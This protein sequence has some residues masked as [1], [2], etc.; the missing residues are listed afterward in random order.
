MQNHLE[1][2]KVERLRDIS[3]SYVKNQPTWSAIMMD[4]KFLKVYIICESLVGIWFISAVFLEITMHPQIWKIWNFH[5]MTVFSSMTSC[6]SIGGKGPRKEEEANN[7]YFK[8]EFLSRCVCVSHSRPGL[9]PHCCFREQQIDQSCSKVILLNGTCSRSFVG[10]WIFEVSE[11][12]WSEYKR[13][14]S[15]S[16][17]TA[18][19]LNHTPEN[20]GDVC[21]H[22]GCHGWGGP[23]AGIWS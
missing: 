4:R 5:C 23:A 11:L 1:S 10:C 18:A 17:Y 19:V 13:E 15:I 3:L 14:G 7:S 21:S 20:T 9:S 2:L 16:C 8:T 6:A 22:F 12:P